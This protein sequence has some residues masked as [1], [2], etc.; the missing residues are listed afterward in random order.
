[1]GAGQLIYGPLSDRFGRRRVLLSGIVLYILTSIL[2]AVSGGVWQLIGLR[3]LQ[4]MGG[5]AA[6]VVARAMVRDFFAGNQAARVLSLIMLVMGMAPLVAPLIGGYVLIWFGWRGVFW[7]LAGFAVGCLVLVLTSLEESHP[8][9]R[10]VRYGLFGTVR[11][12]FRILSHRRACGYLL[13][14]ALAYAGMFA[15]FAGSPFVYIR[16]FEVAPEH[17]GFLFGSNIIGMMA[18]SLWNSRVVL[19]FGAHRLF[20]V[21]TVIVAVSGLVLLLNVVAGFGGL[22]G[23]VVPLFCYIA[24]LGLIGANG[25]ARALDYFPLTAG[26]VSALS[27]GSSFGVGALAAMAVG[28]FRQTD[29]LPMAA[30]IAAAGIS[31]LAVQYYMTGDSAADLETGHG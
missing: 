24:S 1:M 17:Y 28:A 10:R 23:I 3:L 31:T 14:S 2:C 29:A 4:A 19:R 12:Y 15:F 6:S 13:S 5:S 20:A 27:G 22:P 16:L 7:V 11:T 9:E 21:G 30:I 25:L 8:P 18:L 26:T